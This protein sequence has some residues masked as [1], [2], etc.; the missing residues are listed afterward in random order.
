MV[1]SRLDGDKTTRG[2]AEKY[3]DSRRNKDSKNSRDIISNKWPTPKRDRPHQHRSLEGGT[4]ERFEKKKLGNCF[5]KRLD[6]EG[7]LSRANGD[8]SAS[9]GQ[10]R[11]VVYADCNTVWER[12]SRDCGFNAGDMGFHPKGESSLGLW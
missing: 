11:E 10:E 6:R 7:Y 9:T 5:R 8:R 4:K 1:S 12:R 2:E 3:N